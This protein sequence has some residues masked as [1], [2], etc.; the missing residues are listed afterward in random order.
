MEQSEGS[1]ARWQWYHDR[2]GR[3]GV[4]GGWEGEDVDK[5]I[6][7]TARTSVPPTVPAR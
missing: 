1:E 6:I 4:E 7:H 2:K 5:M 3:S